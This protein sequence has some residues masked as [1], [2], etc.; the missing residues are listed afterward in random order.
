MQ[1]LET[2]HS[3]R[4]LKSRKKIITNIKCFEVSKSQK[5]RN[6]L[7]F[8]SNKKIEKPWNVMLPLTSWSW[9]LFSD[10]P[11]IEHFDMARED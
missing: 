3:P 4:I 10:K 7:L 6:F 11:K 8:I 9:V 2:F 5:S 1:F